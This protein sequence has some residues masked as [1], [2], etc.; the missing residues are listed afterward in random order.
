MGIVE[1]ASQEPPPVEPTP[2]QPPMVEQKTHCDLQY[3][4]ENG[5]PRGLRVEHGKYAPMMSLK[6]GNKCDKI[7]LRYCNNGQ[8][9]GT[10]NRRFCHLEESVKFDPSQQSCTHLGKTYK[11]GD[12]VV[13]FK[14]AR[15]SMGEACQS[16]VRIC[17]NGALTGEANYTAQSCIPATSSTSDSMCSSAN[18]QLQDGAKVL[19]FTKELVGDSNYSLAMASCSGSQLSLPSQFF[20]ASRQLTGYEALPNTL[21]FTQTVNQRGFTFDYTGQPGDG[22]CNL[23]VQLASGV[24]VRLPTPSQFACDKLIIGMAALLP[25][26]LG[27]DF[28]S[29]GSKKLRIVN[30]VGSIQTEAERLLKCEVKAGSSLPTPS[31]DED[32]DGAWD[33]SSNGLYR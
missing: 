30:E 25:D 8:L 18:L 20:L 2:Y 22:L 11:H 17:N 10:F 16:Q 12:H 1:P 28:W 21:L 15:P 7:E 14:N 31:V 29:M 3:L 27:I 24:W 32:C 33:N 9:D 4:D 23:E 5:S 13:L 26:S 19:G 6:S